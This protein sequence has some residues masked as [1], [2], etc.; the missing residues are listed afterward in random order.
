[1]TILDQLAEAAK[2]RVALEKAHLPLADIKKAA[3]EALAGQSNPTPGNTATDWNPYPAELPVPWSKVPANRPSFKEA[4]AQPALSFICEVKQASPSKG[5]IAERFDY[6]Q[7]AKDYEAAGAAAISVLT[8]PQW[9][10]GSNQYLAEI[11]A[12]V[13]IPVL[14][15]DFTVDEYMIY[16]AKTLGASAVLLIVAILSDAQ[17]AQYLAITKELGMDAL[18]E[19]HDK[20]ELERAVAAGAEIIGINNRD[21]HTFN[22]NLETTRELARL[23]PDG[24]LLVSES[25]IVDGMDVLDVRWAGADAVLIGETLM[26]ASDKRKALSQLREELPKVKICGLTT[27]EEIAIVNEAEPDYAGFVFAPSRRQVSPEQAAELREHLKPGITPVGVFVDAD[28]EFITDLYVRGVIE[29]AQL[30]GSETEEDVKRLQRR[31]IPVIKAVQITRGD[32]PKAQTRADYLLVDSSA[33][34]GEAF[35]W[36]SI[37]ELSRKTLPPLILAGG[38]SIDNVDQALEEVAPAV[39]DVSS[40]VE[41]DGKKDK[42]KVIAFVNAVRGHK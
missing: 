1:M 15:K 16:E 5:V 25:G 18:V 32:D 31:G 13:D 12:A 14:R 42:E 35:D 27:P 36:A 8:E 3:A 24:T 40:S 23:V 4:I 26:R 38:I 30:H 20:D 2:A 21:L 28:P 10:H 33:G 7:I 29:I 9:F 19:V 41:T 17:L 39:V 22:V 6:L 37:S 11:A 34:S